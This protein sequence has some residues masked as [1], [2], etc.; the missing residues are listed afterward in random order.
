MQKGARVRISKGK[1][2]SEIEV[3]PSKVKMGVWYLPPKV[4]LSAG[5]KRKADES[6]LDGEVVEDFEADDTPVLSAVTADGSLAM[7]FDAQIAGAAGHVLFDSA[8]T[9]NFIP[10]SLCRLHGISVSSSPISVILGN[11]S[12]ASSVGSA[13]VY[14]KL[15]AF[16]QP[17]QCVVLPDLLDGIDLI[18][19]N[20]FMLKYKVDLLFSR[21]VCTLKKGNRRITIKQRESSRDRA[22]MPCKSDS[23][24]SAMQ[25]KR[26]V[27]KG[28]S[29][30]LAVVTDVSADE[31]PGASDNWVG[32]LINEFA[33]V[34]VDPLPP[35]L[36]P[37]RGVGHSIPTEPGHK[38][39]FRPMYRLSP[40]EMREA[41]AQLTKF[42]ADGI[43][44]PSKSPYGAPILFVLKPNGRGLR[45]CVD[46]RALNSVT[47][48]NRYPIPRIDDLLD[49]VQGAQYFT[50][51]DLTSGYHQ[52]RISDEDVSK[53]AFRTP[54]GHYEFK[55]LIEGLTNAPATF[56]TT[57][58]E[59]FRPYL[60]DFVVVYLDDVLI[61]SKTLEDHQKHVRTVLEILRKE[62]FSCK[63][64]SDFCKPE[65]KFLEHIVS[66][67]GV[68]VNPAK[69][70]PVADWPRP[71]KS[72]RYALS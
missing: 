70:A 52:I 61:Y 12:V 7:C 19:G 17:V 63:A 47:I 40:L 54:F 56:Q 8:A 4:N 72:M 36:P 2:P 15:G 25:V 6:R 45:L 31:P 48:K 11:K 35:G 27:R 60:R 30:M 58:N 26:V 13:R 67:E 59:I 23:V 38:P 14:L 42:I 51:L 69:I 10:E 1:T 22:P 20:A 34:F 5:T 18:L 62:Q 49:A 43:V 41:K 28:Q 39:P 64:K 46:Y 24:L 33:D 65:I 55:V 29:V 68:K 37:E 50:S 3:L 16:H 71:K 53:T 32:Q 66:A 57:M 44:Q 21:Q 9:E